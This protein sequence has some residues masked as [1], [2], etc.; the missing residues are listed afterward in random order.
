MRSSHFRDWSSESHRA[1]SRKLLTG[2]R[3]RSSH[4]R[5]RSPSRKSLTENHENQMRS[6]YSRDRSITPN[7]I[8]SSRRA[9]SP[10]RTSLTEYRMHSSHSRGRSLSSK[11][12]TGSRMH[13]SHSRA[14]YPSRKSS[15]TRRNRM[16]SSSPNSSIYSRSSSSSLRSYSTTYTSDDNDNSIYTIIIFKLFSINSYFKLS[17]FFVYNLGG[18]RRSNYRIQAENANISHARTEKAQARDRRST[19]RVS[20]N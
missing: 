19:I 15:L 17:K 2:N 5:A 20:N 18:R 1:S 7:P 13:S 9:R 6:S 11:S 10:S 16:R 4:S 14:R 3:M 12:L 8:S